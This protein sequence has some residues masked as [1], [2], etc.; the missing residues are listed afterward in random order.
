MRTRRQRQLDQLS[1]GGQVGQE[2]ESLLQKENAVAA[3]PLSKKDMLAQWK[4]TQIETPRRENGG[5]Q[6]PLHDG[7]ASLASNGNKGREPLAPRDV[8][9]NASLELNPEDWFPPR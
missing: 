5:S 7:L 2:N 1:E 9:L 4:K 3:T 6:Q 8:N